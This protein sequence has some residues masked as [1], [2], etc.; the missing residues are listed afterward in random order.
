MLDSSPSSLV[1]CWMWDLVVLAY[2]E[3]IAVAAHQNLIIALDYCVSFHT[4]LINKTD[5]FVLSVSLKYF[6]I[7]F[8]NTY[9]LYHTLIKYYQTYLNKCLSCILDYTESWN[10]LCWCKKKINEKAK[11]PN[12]CYV[13]ALSTEQ[14]VYRLDMTTSGLLLASSCNSRM[15]FMGNIDLHIISITVWRKITVGHIS[16]M[17]LKCHSC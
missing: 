16:I 3:H 1:C 5:G 14:S 7:L 11:Y 10:A 4:L 8:N 17:D 13:K 6:I 12:M 9:S 15:I 2:R